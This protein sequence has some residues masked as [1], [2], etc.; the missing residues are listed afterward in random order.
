MVGPRGGPRVT[1]YDP[2]G[3]DLVTSCARSSAGAA[4]A[5]VRLVCD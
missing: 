5:R 3:Y 1:A 2:R 4:I